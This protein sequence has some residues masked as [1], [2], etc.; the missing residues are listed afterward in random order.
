[1]KTE[2]FHRFEKRRYSKPWLIVGIDP[3]T[4]VAYAILDLNGTVI[5]TLSKK[6]LDLSSLITEI[7]KL[8]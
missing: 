4:T 5:K 3:G 8:G 6:E 1:M 7:I 2:S